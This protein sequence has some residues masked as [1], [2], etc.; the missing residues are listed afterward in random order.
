ME[1]TKLET[2]AG[3]MLQ[4]DVG[5][6]IAIATYSAARAPYGWMGGMDNVM[7]FFT[8]IKNP[9]GRRIQ[10]LKLDQ[11]LRLLPCRA[12]VLTSHGPILAS[13][14][15]AEGAFG[16]DIR[17]QVIGSTICA[18]AHLCEPLTAAQLFCRFFL[19]YYFGESNPLADTLHGQ[20]IEQACLTQIINEGA[21]RG[22]ND[23]F[24]KTVDELRIPVV[25]HGWR[26]HKLASQTFDGLLGEISMIGG[27]LRFVTQDESS[28]Y[29]TRSSAVACV[30]ACLKSVGH[31]IG[32]IHTWDGHG[33]PPTAVNPRSLTLV[34]GGSSGTDPLMEDL[35]QLPNTTLILHYQYKTVGSML[36]SAL[37]C[38]LDILVETLQADFEH[39]YEYVE[40]N[41]RVD[42]VLRK[43]VSRPA[44]EFSWE[45][46]SGKACSIARR[47]AAI[48][49]PICA[50][51][52]APCYTRIASE[53]CLSMVR[54]KVRRAVKPGRPELARFRAV[55]A[56]IAISI[57]SR[58][59]PSSFKNVSHATVMELDD[60]HWVSELC[61]LL[62]NHMDSGSGLP[63]R[64][65]IFIL[66]AVHA[67]HEPIDSEK[68]NG[69]II[70]W[71]NGVYG[72]VPD[73][74]LGMAIYSPRMHLVCID[75]FWANVKV[76]E[77]G[78]IRSSQTPDLQTYDS[79]PISNPQALQKPNEPGLGQVI[80]C[81]PDTPL[82][83]S[84]GTPLYLGE[85][86]LCLIGRIGGSVAG[87]VGIL[88]VLWALLRSDVEPE[89]CP[90][91]SSPTG[92]WNVKA[93][94]WARQLYTKPISW[95]YPTFVPVVGDHCW[96]IF[97]VGQTAMQYNGRVVYRCV[98]CAV[99]N[100]VPAYGLTSGKEIHGVFVGLFS[101]N[102]ESAALE[103]DSADV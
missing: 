5:I 8:K 95:L 18:L 71:R 47:L 87:T 23:L 50:E 6:E 26:S 53:H 99:E 10:Q 77:D 29:F 70:G 13:I 59:A 58:L 9:F 49:F 85:P 74:L 44:A 46:P 88:D 25:N 55:T 89:T 56:A 65:A 14:D 16:A 73:L 37:R 24:K 80:L 102:A 57:A 38:R 69:K 62:D 63:L 39:V 41:L 2:A 36:M 22:Y 48:H 93:S 20:L 64:F 21:S 35:Q 51:L 4:T 67:A 11:S 97:L 86:D 90:G 3:S 83:L 54:P 15:D 68:T 12:Y 60:E 1:V 98:D 42:F 19:P 17:T 34:L 75:Y 52:V 91:H 61:T 79:D 84:L 103:W 76:R 27:L 40:S 33:V 81:S 30:A 7:A 66:A 100:F 96:A 82:H 45:E 43:E 78:S 32:D 92:V 94:A 72:I 101:R 28:H 31:P